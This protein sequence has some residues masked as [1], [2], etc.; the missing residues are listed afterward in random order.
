MES[1]F[2]KSK[3]AQD[4]ASFVCGRPK[5]TLH[6][7]ELCCGEGLKGLKSASPWMPMRVC[8]RAF[9]I[10]V[11]VNTFINATRHGEGQF[12]PVPHLKAAVAKWASAVK[13]KTKMLALPSTEPE[14]QGVQYLKARFTIG[15]TFVL[16]LALVRA[17]SVDAPVEASST[18]FECYELAFFKPRAHPGRLIKDDVVFAVVDPYPENKHFF[19]SNAVARVTSRIVVRAHFPALCDGPRV[20]QEWALETW[21]LRPLCK[22]NEMFTN[23]VNSLMRCVDMVEESRFQPSRTHV[24]LPAPRT[25]LIG[26]PSMPVVARDMPVLMDDAVAADA[27]ALVDAEAVAVSRQEV[28]V[29]AALAENVGTRRA[30]SLGD[31]RHR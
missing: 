23:V 30:F 26:I 25:P 17:A 9:F 1:I 18:T 8:V 15:A 2:L 13:A 12:A 24:A 10:S 11:I 7:C 19:S 6:T 20:R 29:F 22:S 16:P 5:G 31:A 28:A 3:C 14:R 21:D 4:G 27:L